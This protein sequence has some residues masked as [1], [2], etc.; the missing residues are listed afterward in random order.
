MILAKERSSGDGRLDALFARRVARELFQRF[1]DIA[2]GEIGQ[3]QADKGVGE[4]KDA[5]GGQ[6]V[7]V[8]APHGL[9]AVGD[10][11]EIAV[12]ALAVVHER[13]AQR[14][15]NARA[16]SFAAAD[17]VLHLGAQRAGGVVLILGVGEKFPLRRQE[18]DTRPAQ[19]VGKLLRV[20]RVELFLGTGIVERRH[21]G[22]QIAMGICH[23]VVVIDLGR[24]DG[25]DN[26]RDRRNGK[27]DPHDAFFHAVF[28]P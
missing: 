6:R 10:A 12:K 23:V 22:A 7:E 20:C 5:D 27:P 15:G 16:E 21:I 14:L 2:R 17:G 13:I 1:E 8:D 25:E 19:C 26:E 4:Q 24:N 28:L 18:R 3:K 9:R 11:H